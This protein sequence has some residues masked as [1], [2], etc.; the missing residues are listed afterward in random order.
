MM[1]EFVQVVDEENYAI[2]R[3]GMVTKQLEMG[4]KHFVAGESKQSN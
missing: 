4:Q 2:H 1:K 3:S